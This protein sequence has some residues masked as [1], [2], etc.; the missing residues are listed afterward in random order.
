MP[1]AASFRFSTYLTFALA[2]VALGYAEYPVLPEV[3]VFA[4]LA[5]VA[6]AVLYFLEAR[7]ALLSIPAANRVGSAVGFVFLLWAA[8][9]VKREADTLEFARMGWPMLIVA[10]F[11]PLIMM[12]IVAKVARR[13]KHAGDYW[14]LHG[15]ALAGVGLAAALAAEPVS[16]VI[17]GLYLFAA[18]WSLSLFYVARADG[19]IL[20]A[21]GRTTPARVVV[22]VN[23][24]TP[25]P[26]FGVRLAVALVAAAAV[27][28][29]PLYLLT[30]RSTSEPA[31]FG[32]PQGE[33]KYSAGQ[34]VDLKR[35]GSLKANKETAF[36]V[37]ATYADGSPKDDLNPDQ[38][39]RGA[40]RRT[41]ADGE[42][43]Q[44]DVPLPRVTPLAINPPLWKPPILG[45]N[46][47]TLTYSVPSPLH[48]TFTADPVL[49]KPRQPPPLATV[50]PH[51]A[52]GW[53]PVGDGTFFW[54]PEKSEQPRLLRYKQVYRHNDDPDLGPPFYLA[55]PFSATRTLAPLM[56]N[57][58]PRVKEYAD[59]VLSELLKAGKLPAECRDPAKLRDPVSLFPRPQ[60]HD[61]IARGFANYLATT[62]T[63]QYTTNLTRKDEE[64]DPIEDFLFN[65]KSGHC[66]RFATALVLMLRSQGI[67][68]VYVFGLKGC[69]FGV[70]GKYYVKQAFTHAWAEAL[71]PEPPAPG[72]EFDPRTA[73][74]HW[75]SLDPTPAGG[76]AA[77]G[78]DRSWFA[79]A[80]HWVKARF[81]EY[82]T[83]F[84]PD[85]RR[86]A[87]ATIA[88]YLT[89]PETLLALA[90]VFVLVGAMRF[91]RRRRRCAPTPPQLAESTRW[92]GE[93]VAV[94]AEQGIVPTVG[95]TPMEFAVSAAATLR[96][97]PG[98]TAVVEVP[99]AWATAYYQD[100][101]GGVPASDARLA[102]LDAKLD[103]LRRAL[104]P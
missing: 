100:R 56:V 79:R 42:W 82:L 101:F 38:R 44:V 29:V 10:M 33:I 97:R 80:G 5:V 14:F 59:R 28:A 81:K 47:F 76:A 91:A 21:P 34:K 50:T 92:F 57:P 69:V 30:P 8:Y 45:R 55:D 2:C 43:K 62:P 3:G 9:R 87:L 12:A 68:A 70:E 48:S 74:Y 83:D 99:L 93:L 49:W 6:L 16:V 58:V 98:C 1:T 94:L 51:G 11:G 86:K 66:E 72:E 73:V 64:L 36:E 54:E 18:V 27:V 32:K 89:R 61:A 65:T 25:G 104:A 95:D 103:A 13:D 39:W 88:G 15:A 20:P 31:E 60:Y 4:G 35:T 96:H 40:T 63:L 102:E 78:V 75:R 37:V 84:T 52:E 77:E 7:V 24:D 53:M 46:Q 41:Y 85:Q 67:P 19:G 23:T 22:P 71:V 26:R 17:V 90:A